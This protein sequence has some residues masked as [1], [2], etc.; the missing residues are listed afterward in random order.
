VSNGRQLGQRALNRALLARQL[1]L[2]RVDS[3][4]VDAIEH[5]VGL[6]AQAPL[7]PYVALWT[8]LASFDQKELAEPLTE[9]ALVRATL[10]RGTVHLVTAR[11]CLTLRPL[12]EP[13]IVRG[14]RG[15]FGRFL[16]G[17]DLDQVR[18]YARELLSNEALTRT[19]LR[20][21]FGARWPDWDADTMAYAASYLVPNLQ[22][23]PRGVWGQTGKAALTTIEAWL[24]RPLEQNPSID[25]I[26][27]RYLRAFGPATVMD[28]QAWSGLTRLREV[29]ERLAPKLRTF[30]NDS[31][32]VLYDVPDAE[33]PDPDT[34]APP[35]FLPEYDNVLLS[36]DDRTRVNADKRPVPLPPGNGAKT[37]TLLVDGFFR[38]LWTVE[39]AALRVTP[40]APLA[41]ADAAAVTEEGH[42]LL[43]FLGNG[44]AE[45]VLDTPG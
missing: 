43:G 15:G 4:P 18:A 33:L 24:G 3:T 23:T 11:D 32:A 16:N 41:P 28:V 37:G 40:F 39:P 5:L 10:M 9:R 30:T 26:V 34:P 2:D 17:V 13:A 6:Q 36:H 38:G 29:V 1:L 12:V 22:A 20:D 42:Q 8:R 19:E 7:A 21:R 14:F 25:D 35:R 45:V 31:G 44:T 27:L